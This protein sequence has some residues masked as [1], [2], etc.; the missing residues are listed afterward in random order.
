VCNQSHE[1]ASCESEDFFLGY[2]GPGENPLDFQEQAR[3]LIDALGDEEDDDSTPETLP[4]RK[5]C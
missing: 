1:L 3:D 4:R 5:K 2:I